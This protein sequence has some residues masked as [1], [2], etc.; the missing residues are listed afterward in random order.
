MPRGSHESPQL[1]PALSFQLGGLY[2][3]LS[4]LGTDKIVHSAVK[5]GQWEQK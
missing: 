2:K 5:A 3:R 4:E 1:P